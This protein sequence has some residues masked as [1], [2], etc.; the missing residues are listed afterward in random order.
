MQYPKKLIEVALPLDDINAAASREKSIRHGHPSTLH[1]WW[2]RRPLAAARAVLFAQLVNDPSEGRT[3]EEAQH[4]REKLFK[5]IRELV[6]WENTNN[7][8]LLAQARDE[9]RKSW[10]ETCQL[11]GENPEKLPPFLDPFSGGGSIPLEAQRLGLEAHGSDLNPVAVMIGK[12]LIEIPPKFAA[13]IPVGAI[14]KK[15]KTQKEINSTEW[16]GTTGLA[17][18]VRRYGA[19]MREEAFKRIGHFYP[20]IDLPKEHGG[21]KATVI[22][23]LWARTVA[24]PNPA[25]NG[26]H[27]PLVR[28][29]WLSKK[30]GKEVWV[31]PVISADGMDY[32]FEVRTGQDKPD[33]EGTMNR[34]GGICLLSGSPMPFTYIR[35]EGKAGR[36]GNQ[37]MAVVAEG[38]KG[39][40]YLEPTQEMEILAKSVKATWKPQ[41]DLPKNPRDFKTPNYGMNTFAELFTPR[42]LVALTT[43]SD[44]VLEAREKVI[45][46][47]KAAGWFDDGKGFNDEGN[48]ATAY[49][50]AV[51]V[52]LALGVSKLTDY[53]AVL[54]SWSN[55]RDQAAHVFTKQALPMVWDFCEVNPFAQ[56]AGDL[57]ISLRSMTKTITSFVAKNIGYGYQKDAQKLVSKSKFIISTD[58]PY[59][60]NLSYADL[61]DFFYVW[62]RRSLTSIFPDIF[63]TLLVPKSQELIASP[64]RHGSKEKAE[65]FFMEGMSRAIHNMAFNTHPAFPVTIYYAFKQSETKK[66]GTASTGWETFLEAVM[67]AGFAITGTW[68]MRTERSTRSVSIGTN[69]LASSIVLVCRKRPDDADIISRKQFQRELSNTLPDALEDMIGGK[70]GNSPIAPVDLAQAA[71]G[72]GMKVFSQYTQVLEADGTPMSV[73]TALTFINHEI[74]DYFVQTEGDMDADTRFCVDWFQQYG[75]NSGPFGEADVLGRAKSISVAGLQETR[76]IKASGGKVRLSKVSEY[77]KHW[78]PRLDKRISIWKACHY[79]NHALQTSESNAGKLLADMPD[80]AEPIRQL[81]YR[82]YTLCERKGWAEE[83]RIYNELITSWLAISE[84]R[85]S[86]TFQEIERDDEQHRIEM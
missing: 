84:A 5:I 6:K 55:S 18:D 21:G 79:L 40:I 46:D 75:F 62:L 71:I 8:E 14:S 61:S 43:F 81:A 68:P 11:T 56:A 80:K 51:A 42:Q 48:G 39:R 78:E 85:T 66:E 47:A 54:V 32:H 65:K 36:M 53:N 13:C 30:K 20:Q 76:V 73:R 1:L 63:S 50:D 60:D 16:P 22:A 17:E 83:A 27:V 67:K 25:L 4:E 24:S 41:N 31:D 52:Y 72:P 45:A 57:L 59:F 64:Y 7:E 3:K 86:E 29:F 2:A 35:A 37:L 49:G 34:K 70:E 12:A 77:P 44:L 69:A 74:D 23:W 9:I 19:W 58:P 38:K 26:V 10:R 15:S 33:I 82:L 28:S